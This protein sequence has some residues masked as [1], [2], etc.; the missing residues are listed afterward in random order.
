M[1]TGDIY[2]GYQSDCT[3]TGWIYLKGF[4]GTNANPF[5][6]YKT[7]NTYKW[8]IY[9]GSSWA[10]TLLRFKTTASTTAVADLAPKSAG[11]FHYT[12]AIHKNAAFDLY[13]N[14][15]YAGAHTP[16]NAG[17]YKYAGTLELYL[18]GRPGYLDETRIRDV[19]SS[20][21]WIRAEYDS[22]KNKDFV[23]A[24]PVQRSGKLILYV[25]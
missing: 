15:E 2:M 12:V 21:D 24:G 17:Y 11:W 6:P 13:I 18:V 1:K 19:L 14:G 9:P 10:K 25:Q 4:T 7:C 22:V 5:G 16:G 3:L 20:A 23:V 8:M